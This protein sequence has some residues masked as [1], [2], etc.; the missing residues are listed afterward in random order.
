MRENVTRA[1]WSKG[2]GGVGQ[3]LVSHLL[4]N[5]LGGNHRFIDMNIYFSDDELRK[6]AES[7]VSRL[8]VTAQ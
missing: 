6:Q 3:S 4:D 5:F 8:A 2:P 1:W 7:M